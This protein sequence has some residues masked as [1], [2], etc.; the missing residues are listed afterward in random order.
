M[1]SANNILSPAN[2]RPLVTPT[3]DMVIGAFYLT[4]HVEG[5]GRGP[6]LPARGGHPRAHERATWR[7]TPR[8]SSARQRGVKARWITTTT[9]GRVI[10]NEALPETSAI[11]GYIQTT[12]KKR[13]LGAI[14]DR[15]SPTTTKA[16]VAGRSTRIK[17]LCYTTPPG[18]GLTVSI[19]DVQDPESKRDILDG[20]RRGRQG[21]DPVPSRHHHRR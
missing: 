15:L 7:C 18:P 2:G 11:V 3:Q 10:F 4:E 8:S 1:L 14:V 12:M 5:A 17:D 6:R 21:R 9:A 19:D 20:T 16:E 13:E